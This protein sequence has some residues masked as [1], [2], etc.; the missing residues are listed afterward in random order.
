[1]ANAEFDGANP[2]ETEDLGFEWGEDQ[3]AVDS[4]TRAGTVL[5]APQ[6]ASNASSF[7]VLCDQRV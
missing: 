3:E 6:G 5:S 2:L 7:L 4:N 1:M